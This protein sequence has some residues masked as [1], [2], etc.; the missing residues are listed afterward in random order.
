MR[1]VWLG[2]VV[3]AVG[4]VG[5]GVARADGPADVPAAG[6]PDAGGPDA[7][8]HEL[9][10]SD[11]FDLAVGT[12]VANPP[13]PA[14]AASA[15]GRAFQSLNPD[16][17]AIMD[18][19]AGFGQRA[20]LRLAGDD[21]DLK[22]GPS[23]HHAGFTVQEAEVGI[24][25]IVDPYF[26]AD[27]F[28]TIPNL[29]G[30]EVEEGVVTTTALPADLQVKA[31]IFRSAFGRQNGQH[32]HLQDFTRRPLV[33]AAYLGADGLRQPGV[34]LSWLAPA[35][36]FLQLI[37]EAFSAG[38]PDDLTQINTFGGGKRTDLTYTAELKTFIP[39]T[40]SL[41]IYGGLN[42][43]VGH[44]PGVQVPASAPDSTLTELAYANQ[45]SVLYAA[46]L[47]VKWKP[48]N[49]VNGYWAV[50]WTTEVF[51]RNISGPQSSSFGSPAN[52][53]DQHDGG[54]YTQLVAQLGRSWFVGVREDV[55]GLPASQL[56]PRESR[57]SASVTYVTSEFARVRAYVEREFVDTSATA[58]KRQGL[59]PS[60]STAGY[61]QLEISMGAHGAHPF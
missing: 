61:I 33:N 39:A 43:A 19:T 30:L 11:Q 14:P 15:V 42:A 9:S 60:D 5:A 20:P 51:Q 4:A 53:Q 48:P 52:T 44:S 3:G 36:F 13:A 59:N 34:Q 17:S 31:G 55:L 7:G 16:I 26:R 50:A 38:P 57:T 21:P 12:P 24:Q 37:G 54:L 25:S 8:P 46:D 29:Q 27:L 32:L 49:Q 35:P 45:L 22:G 56:Q 6:L 10:L 40:E 58:V 2:L 28:L 47:Y 1:G 23:D 41:S 18:L